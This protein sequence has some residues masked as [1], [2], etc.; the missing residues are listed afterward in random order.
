[1]KPTVKDGDKVSRGDRLSEGNIKPQELAELKGTLEA[2]QYIVNEVVSLYEDAGRTIRRPLVETAI[3]QV[4]RHAQ[5]TDPGDSDSV[6]GDYLPVNEI[7][8]RNKSLNKKIIY[9]EVVKGIGLAPFLSNDFLTRL[10]F[11]RIPE[12]IQRGAAQGW[13]SSLHGT[14]PIPGYAFGAEYGQSPTAGAKSP[15]KKIEMPLLFKKK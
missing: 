2:K 13:K 6:I 10:N 12:A 11:E 14:N 15:E 9:K 8:F 3:G 1:M 5:I 7:E 4:I